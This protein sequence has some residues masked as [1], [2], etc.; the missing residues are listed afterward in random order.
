MTDISI[1]MGECWME[2]Y[3][4]EVRLGNKAASLGEKLRLLET[5]MRTLVSSIFVHIFNN[6]NFEVDWVFPMRPSPLTPLGFKA[7]EKEFK[8][9][10]LATLEHESEAIRNKSQ[11]LRAKA[12]DEYEAALRKEKL[13]A[14]PKLR[15]PGEGEAFVSSGVPTFSMLDLMGG[16]EDEAGA[17]LA[18]Q[19]TGAAHFENFLNKR[20]GTVQALPGS[21]YDK[22]V[23]PAAANAA[24]SSPPQ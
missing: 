5:S 12:R 24:P 6:R 16:D 8:E 9:A 7:K 2:C 4:I 17:G 18:G 3:S 19:S 13:Q 11:L 10:I 14:P 21:R 15:L 22:A 23:D 1:L 20:R